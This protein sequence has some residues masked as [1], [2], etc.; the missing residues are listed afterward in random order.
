MTIT[1]YELRHRG[2]LKGQGRVEKHGG[3]G[4]PGGSMV[5]NP[6]C[7]CR[8]HKVGGFDPWVRKIP[9]SRK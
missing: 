4:F 3:G 5:K 2:I 9:W 1:K 8:R 7:Q 6:S